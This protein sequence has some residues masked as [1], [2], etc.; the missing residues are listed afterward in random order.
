MPGTGRGRVIPPGGRECVPHSGRTQLPFAAW[1]AA[2]ERLY[3]QNGHSVVAETAVTFARPASKASVAGGK[4]KAVSLGLPVTTGKGTQRDDDTSYVA[5]E[6]LPESFSPYDYLYR[7]YRGCVALAVIDESHNGRGRDTDI[8][9]AHHQ[10]M[11]VSQT[12]MLTSGTHL[13]AIFWVSIISGTGIIRSSGGAWGWVGTTR[14][15]VSA[16]VKLLDNPVGARERWPL[17]QCLT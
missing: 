1:S 9:H 13:A 2:V 15:A 7:F 14:C 10:A 3:R 4:R 17:G 11:L 8:A 12:R 5:R 16:L 6:T